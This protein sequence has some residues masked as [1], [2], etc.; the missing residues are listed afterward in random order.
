MVL[1]YINTCTALEY[2]NV[3]HIAKNDHRQQRCNVTC[4]LMMTALTKTGYNVTLLQT[5]L[6]WQLFSGHTPD[7]VRTD[8]LS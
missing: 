6:W 5:R 3:T 8:K 2:P 4:A 7:S 1:S